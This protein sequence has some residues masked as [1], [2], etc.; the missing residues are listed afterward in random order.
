MTRHDLDRVPRM[1]YHVAL[2]ISEQIALRTEG[3]S[4]AMLQSGAIN[5]LLQALSFMRDFKMRPRG[6]RPPVL[7]V[8][9][10]QGEASFLLA[11]LQALK[12]LG[13]L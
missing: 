9:G 10:S 2:R 12:S 8:L 4:P 11:L 6:H 7:Q 3:W 13:L 1:S 5:R